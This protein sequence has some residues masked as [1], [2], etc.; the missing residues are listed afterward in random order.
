M[1]I[2]IHCK[3]YG[4]IGAASDFVL[5]DILVYPVMGTL[6]FIARVLSHGVEGFLEESLSLGFCL[7]DTLTPHCRG[8]VRS[9]YLDLAMLRWSPFMVSHGTRVL[10]CRRG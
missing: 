2:L 10:S 3:V 1:T 9:S 5:E 7:H 4:A 6:I 8:L